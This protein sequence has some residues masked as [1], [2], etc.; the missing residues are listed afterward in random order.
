MVVSQGRRL[1]FIFCRFRQNPIY[2]N[3]TFKYEIPQRSNNKKTPYSK[4]R[5]EKKKCRAKGGQEIGG[6]FIFGLLKECR[7]RRVL[8]QCLL[9]DRCVS[10]P[11]V[12]PEVI[13]LTLEGASW[14]FEAHTPHPTR[15]LI[16]CDGYLKN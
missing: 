8:Q 6:F 11:P 1:V 16:Y 5:L 14:G 12:V 7:M 4:P 9:G 10:S 15:I 13:P 3:N 2:K